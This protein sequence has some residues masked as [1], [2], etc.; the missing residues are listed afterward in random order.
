M[1]R[2]LIVR[3]GDGRLVVVGKKHAGK[4]LEEVA[5][6]DLAY[7]IFLRKK[8]FEG[9]DDDVFYALDDMLVKKGVNLKEL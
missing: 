6:E 8:C 5:D 4:T 1:P 2:P 9:L 7:L 3:E